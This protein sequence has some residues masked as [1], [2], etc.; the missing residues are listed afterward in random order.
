MDGTANAFFQSGLV[1]FAV[2]Y[3]PGQ[4]DGAQ[5]T[6]FIRQK[7]LLTARVRGLYL[8]Q[9]RGRI[10][11]VDVVQKNDPRFSALPGSVHDPVKDAFGRDPSDDIPA[12]RVDQTI[13]FVGCQ[14]LHKR[15]SEGNRDIEV[16]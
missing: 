13:G 3:H 4:I 10:R 2:F 9:V 15:G 16:V 5:V 8:T 1:Q 11:L 6:R 7:R 12:P 14:G